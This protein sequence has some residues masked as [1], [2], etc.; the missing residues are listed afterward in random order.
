MHRSDLPAPH[1]TNG[2]F[3]NKTCQVLFQVKH[4]KFHRVVWVS[5]G[6]AGH[7]TPNGTGHIFR[8]VKGWVESTLYPGAYMLDPMF[9]FPD[10][11]GIALHGSVSNDLVQA[12]PGKPRVCSR[13]A[14]TDSQDL[15]GVAARHHSEDLRPKL[16]ML[17]RWG[18]WGSNPRPRDY[19]L[20][21][22]GTGWED[23]RPMK[24]RSADVSPGFPGTCLGN[25]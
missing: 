16:T 21:R 17:N 13:L 9:F 12:L 11:P 4:H 1:R 25:R 2:I 14:P 8:K 18:G 19:E 15:Q 7:E 22:E 24:Q 5:S 3:V 6:M 23:L 10:R 20:V